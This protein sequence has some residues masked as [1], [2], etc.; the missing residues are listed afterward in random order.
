MTDERPAAAVV[1]TKVALP[2]ALAAVCALNK[3]PVDAVPTDIGAVGV[4]RSSAPGDPE[5]AAQ[6]ISSVL[7][8]TPVVLL[9]QRDG[10][11]TAGR[12]SGGEEVEELTAALMLDGAPPE[13]EA[14]LLGATDP[15]QLP[16]TVSSTGMSR[17]RAMRILAGATRATRRAAKRAAGRGRDADPPPSVRDPS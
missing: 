9:V 2:E 17:L 6:I 4:C 8:T 1:L 14:L 10:Q 7:S 16:G 13:V 11:V 12:W 5:T 3:V 15:G